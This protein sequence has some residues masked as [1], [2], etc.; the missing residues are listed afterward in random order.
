[1]FVGRNSRLVNY[2]HSLGVLPYVQICLWSLAERTDLKAVPSKW[3]CKARKWEC[4]IWKSKQF[5]HC[6]LWTQRKNNQNGKGERNFTFCVEK[7]A[8]KINGDV[9]RWHSNWWSKYYRVHRNKEW[10]LNLNE[11]QNEI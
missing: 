9:L 11:N 4:G 5:I 3:I 10:H 2:L 1:M 8:E 6:S 7:V